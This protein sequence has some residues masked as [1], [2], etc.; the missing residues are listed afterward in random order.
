[1]G[2]S[3]SKSFYNLEEL[4]YTSINDGNYEI[5]NIHNGKD[6]NEIFDFYYNSIYNIFKNIKQILDT[7]KR[8]LDFKDDIIIYITEFEEI[9]N[10]LNEYINCLNYIDYNLNEEKI[11]N[12]KEK[13]IN[14][15]LSHKSQFVL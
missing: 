7:K 15:I 12:Y 3:K 11:S 9:I 13:T 5:I 2:T 10:Q 6:I 4:N 14:L 1:M 8:N